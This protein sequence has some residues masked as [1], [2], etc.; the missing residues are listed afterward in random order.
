MYEMIRME[1]HSPIATVILSRRERRNA[2]NNVMRREL[3]DALL[4]IEQN[5]SI[6]AVIIT[7]DGDAFCAGADISELQS[8]TVVEGAWPTIIAGPH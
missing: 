2:L 6:R 5:E 3:V 7:G 4:A 1:F 8:R